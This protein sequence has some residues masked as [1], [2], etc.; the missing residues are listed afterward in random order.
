VFYPQLSDIDG[1]GDHLELNQILHI[2]QAPV[3]L[4]SRRFT[5]RCQLYETLLFDLTSESDDL[6]NQM[7]RTGRSQVRKADRISD[8]IE[9]RRNDTAAY[10]DFLFVYNS[11][12]KAKKHTEQITSARIE[13]L[14]PF[15][16]V[17]VAYFE[18][19]PIC[20]HVIIRDH[21]LARVGI[22]WSASTRL[23]GEDA[24][25][26]V[27]SLN[28]WLHWYEMRLYKSQGFRVYDFGGI[29]DSTPEIQAITRFK[30]SFGGTR[31]VEHDCM[32]AR[33]PGHL[34]VNLLYAIRRL[35]QT[36]ARKT[37]QNGL[38]PRQPTEQYL[39]AQR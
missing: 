16:D 3:P 10:R 29:G 4:P 38:V 37:L 23:K 36:V 11:F 5:I 35:R 6:F 27:A 13:A 9:V 20:G 7:N 39:A 8:R 33:A 2:R 14:K 24:P 15:S 30:L 1:L 19:R 12:V 31:V 17:L 22:L 32:M 34:A 21:T 18:G 25:L 26:L 28:R